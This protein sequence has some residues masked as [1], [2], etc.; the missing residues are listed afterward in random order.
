MRRRQK[1]RQLVFIRGL[2]DK[3][4]LLAPKSFQ[5]ELTLSTAEKC[6]KTRETACLSGKLSHALQDSSEAE[7][8]CEALYLQLSNCMVKTTVKWD[9]G[10]TLLSMQ[11]YA[12]SLDSSSLNFSTFGPFTTSFTLAI[13]WINWIDNSREWTNKL[14]GGGPRNCSILLFIDAIKIHCSLRI[15]NGIG[16]MTLHHFPSF[17]SACSC[18]AHRRSK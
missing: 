8:C 12:Q 9:D 13:G 16:S 15:K 14:T 1:L 4:G 10:R 17:R 7:S 3:N 5:P 2:W 6:S 11:S 18:I